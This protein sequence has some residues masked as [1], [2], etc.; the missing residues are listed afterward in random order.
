METTEIEKPG[1]GPAAGSSHLTTDQKH[2]RAVYV[3]AVTGAAA[4]ANVVPGLSPAGHWLR[5]LRPIREI[6]FV[7]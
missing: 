3:M 7:S 6:G 4:N 2:F 5:N 1:S